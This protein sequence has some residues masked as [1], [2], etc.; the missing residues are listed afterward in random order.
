MPANVSDETTRRVQELA[1]QGYR[2]IDCAGMGRMDFFVTP[3]DRIII[4]EINTLPG[5][6]P[7]SM[8]PLLWDHAGVSYADLIGRL[9]D[10]GLERHEERA[11]G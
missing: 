7:T 2:S 4:D 11:N 9:V 10:L 5:F 8:Y 1:V 6:T 3:D